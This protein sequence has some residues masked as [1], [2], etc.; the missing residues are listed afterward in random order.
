[1]NKIAIVAQSEFGTLVRSKAFII[2]VILMP[3]VMAGSIFLVR[4]T[5][6]STD[7]KDRS[8]AYVD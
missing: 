4:A 3:V 7:V 6:D 5:R 2:S 1:M 8:F